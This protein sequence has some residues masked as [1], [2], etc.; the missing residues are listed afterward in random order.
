[1]REKF[2]EAIERFRTF[3]GALQK[4]QRLSLVGAAVLVLG[5]ILAAAFITG[6]TAYEPIFS[7]LDARDEDAVITYLKEEGIP[8][9]T[10]SQ[11]KAILVPTSQVYEARISLAS[12]GVPAGDVGFELFDQ[13]SLGK[14]SFQ[15][16]VTYFR[17]LEGELSRTLREV[18]SV[19]S[20]RVSIVVPESKLFLEQ[21][22]PS[23]AAVVLKLQSGADFSPEMARAIVHLV[24]HSVEGLI[25][26]NVTLVDADGHISFD[27][28]LDDSLFKTGDRLVL[29]QREYEKYYEA[30]LQKK[31]KDVLEKAFGHGKIAASI[32]VELDFDKKQTT[33]KILIP[34]DGKIHGPLQSQQNMEE[35]YTGPAGVYGGPPGTTSNIPGYEVSQGQGN[36]QSEYSRNE[37]INN[38]DNST[39]ESQ[40]VET[41]PKIKR[42][43]ALV[44]IDRKLTKGETDQW[45][46]A[47]ASAILADESR[48]DMLTVIGVPF[49]TSVVD[50]LQDRMDAEQRK[51]L[52]LGVSSFVIFLL[53]LAA[54]FVLW[55]RRRRQLEALQRARAAM[56]MEEN[57]SLRE[58][59][60]NPDLMTSQG[61]LS[62]LEEQLRN[63]AM[64]NPEELANLIKNWVVDDV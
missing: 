62:V 37:T 54:G 1:M 22:Q 60:E 20:A 29:K 4:W 47:V 26:E 16:K 64:N 57:P 10:D 53:A 19:K 38:Y 52:V 49:D 28:L 15:E 31:I 63:Y 50:V 40:Q 27:D 23:T 18:K 46:S 24:S 39:Q 34:I 56:E 43:S 41:A 58:L 33:S 55:L 30:D 13:S 14:T 44:L 7:R 9:K 5:G 48:G 6:R 3:W 25:P 45:R 61:E 42:A 59:L 32:R 12:K 51:R 36:G 17:A 35:N 11:A 21:R 2:A 8:Y